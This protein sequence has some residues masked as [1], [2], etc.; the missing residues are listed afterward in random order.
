LIRRRR[1]LWPGRPCLRLGP[2]PSARG[3]TWPCADGEGLVYNR[4]T[5]GAGPSSR[6]W[7]APKE[8][9]PPESGAS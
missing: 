9:A 2:S 5:A 1:D 8:K 7:T 4:K 6:A 3:G